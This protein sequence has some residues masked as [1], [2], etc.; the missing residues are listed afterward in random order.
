MSVASSQAQN[1]YSGV[2]FILLWIFATMGGFVVS[3]L[4]VE[5]GEAPDMRIGEAAIGGLAIALPQSCILRKTIS[6]VKWV[7]STFFIWSLIAAIGIGALGWSVSTTDFIPQRIFSG[8]ISGGIGGLMMG[9][10]QWSLAIPPSL[11]SAWQ[12]I[13]VNSAAWAVALPIGSTLGIFFRQMS[14]LYLGEVIGLAV[15]WIIVAVVTGISA[16]KVLT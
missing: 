11:S 13:F 8:I 2:F 12:W 9:L 1:R 4:I 3:L 16:E 6:P 7:L 15:T 5:V 10:A 14:Q